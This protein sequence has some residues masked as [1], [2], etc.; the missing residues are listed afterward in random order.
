[1][2]PAILQINRTDPKTLHLSHRKIQER[3]RGNTLIE[4]VTGTGTGTHTR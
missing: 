3:E 4:Q 1:M 2:L